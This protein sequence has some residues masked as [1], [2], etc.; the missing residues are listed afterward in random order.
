MKS[1]FFLAARARF[2][3]CVCD[4]RLLPLL[5]ADGYFISHL[6]CCDLLCNGAIFDELNSDTEVR[7]EEPKN[8]CHRYNG[9]SGSS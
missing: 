5:L 3:R 4:F 9:G 7:F 6:N 1:L 8:G 2:M